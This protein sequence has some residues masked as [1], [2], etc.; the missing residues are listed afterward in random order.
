MLSANESTIT[1]DM[2]RAHSADI[3]FLKLRAWTWG[4]TAS[5]AALCIGNIAGVFGI[6]IFGMLFELISEILW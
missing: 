6:N 2:T 1:Y 4:I 5:V 3:W